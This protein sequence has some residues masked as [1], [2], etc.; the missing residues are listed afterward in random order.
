MNIVKDSTAPFFKKEYERSLHKIWKSRVNGYWTTEARGADGESYNLKIDMDTILL[1]LKLYEL[2]LNKKYLEE[3]CK[4]VRKRGIDYNEGKVWK[5]ATKINSPALETMP[6][7]ADTTVYSLLLLSYQQNKKS[8]NLSLQPF[9]TIRAKSGITLFFGPRE[10]DRVDPIINCG[11]AILQI[12]LKK[13]D[14]LFYHIQSYLNQLIDE[15]DKGKQLSY[16]Y[17]SNCF[18]Y[19]RLAKIIALDTDYFSET[20][21]EKIITRLMGEE[22]KSSLDIAWVCSSL[23][24]LGCKQKAKEIAKKI[25]MN[26]DRKNA[27]WNFDTFYIQNNPKFYYGSEYITS[28]YC[29]EALAQIK[30]YN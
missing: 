15:I 28:I 16:W 25:V 20:M 17:T 3:G 9:E 11:F 29:L 30:N 22:P 14:S 13:R 18:V 26:Y 4:F 8:E 10:S 1:Y 21:V 6:P 2:T 12:K 5:F 7:D 27:G 24:L 23:F 19:Y